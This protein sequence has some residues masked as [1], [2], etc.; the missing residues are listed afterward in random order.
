MD[1][2]RAYLFRH[3]LLRDAARQLHV[4]SVRAR[5][6]GLVY[7]I[8][9][10][11]VGA[12]PQ[13]AAELADHAL[14]AAAARGEEEWRR[15]ELSHLK[16]GAA[17]ASNS[18]SNHEALALLSRIARHPLATSE[19]VTD[20][21]C[22]RAETYQLLG[23]GREVTECIRAAQ[24]LEPK[25]TDRQVRARLWLAVA[26]QLREKQDAHVAAEMML[27]AEREFAA[28]G[29]TARQAVCAGHYATCHLRL[30]NLAIAADHAWRAVKLARESG[31][32]ARLSVVLSLLA[33]ILRQTGQDADVR[34]MYQEAMRLQRASGDLHALAITTGNLAIFENEAGNA[35]EAERLY[36][37]AMAIN[38][39]V[40]DRRSEGV[41]SGNY[42]LL[43]RSAGRPQETERHLRHALAVFKESGDAFLEAAFLTNLGNL[44]T[45]DGRYP[46]AMQT[47][48][49][50]IRMQRMVN[51][52]GETAYNYMNMGWCLRKWGR[53]RAARKCLERALALFEAGG[54]VAFLASTL[55]RIAEM[56]M[57]ERGPAHAGASL[58]R[59]GELLAGDGACL[60]RALMYHA[61]AARRLAALA[62]E[63]RE[64]APLA[65]AR[66]HIAQMQRIAR[67][68]S[69]GDD[70]SVAEEA[71]KCG[72]V[73]ADAL[74]VITAG[75]ASASFRGHFPDEMTGPHR[76]AVAAKLAQE[77]PREWAKLLA[78]NAALCSALAEGGPA[79][80]WQDES[81]L[82]GLF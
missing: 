12:A 25:V 49:R 39:R 62:I 52:T 61:L 57:Q 72:A 15:R 1:A 33:N 11:A 63:Q 65:E 22:R 55:S 56:D 50:S 53:L 77:Q 78:G 74:N 59:A 13:H 34:S 80:D 51:N 28:A 17:H 45:D 76:R 31:A 79:P 20:A 32:G 29:D 18:Y 36:L 27:N 5:L 81:E 37:E 43:L 26:K 19:D 82:E 10:A 9:E 41:N 8:L 2:E 47:Y 23:K 4:P 38:R 68:A 71:R 16:V 66:S 60:R 7:E 69:L 24:D 44:L 30:G 70:S 42:G 58:D 46:D 67:Q 40:G 75:G 14:E 6:H 73:L 21:H 35:A 3:A 48:R 64:E 54:E